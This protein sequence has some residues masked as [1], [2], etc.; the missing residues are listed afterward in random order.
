MYTGRICA[1]GRHMMGWLPL[2]SC[3]TVA[4][5]AAVTPTP[6]PWAPAH[7]QL[8]TRWAQAVS[9][10]N[11][12]PEHPRPDASRGDGSWLTLNGLWDADGT[13]QDLS[14]PPFWPAQMPRKILVPFP[15]E[16]ALSG[17]RELPAH[18]HMWYRLE[19]TAAPCPHLPSTCTR[20][21]RVTATYAHL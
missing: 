4:S 9:P 1:T 14:H 3:I 20:Y 6:A 5:P 10:T 12:H 19:T 2:I 16:A 18:Q 8:L 13:P 11:A 7:P 17:I 21:R 15:F